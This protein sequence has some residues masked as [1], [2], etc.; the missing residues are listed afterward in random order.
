M[1][2]IT[3]MVL[4]LLLAGRVSA[5]DAPEVSG[6]R[7]EAAADF[8]DQRYEE[9]SEL[10]ARA[11]ALNP[12][13][14][15]LRTHLLEALSYAKRSE[16]NADMQR[17]AVAEFRN[18]RFTQS[19]DL[20]A[21]AAALTPDDPA[22]LKDWMWAL[23]GAKRYDEAA[24]VAARALVLHKNDEEALRVQVRALYY[25]GHTEDAYQLYIKSHNAMDGMIPLRRSMVHVYE[26]LREYDKAV[27]LSEQLLRSQPRDAVLY[28][29]VGRS[30]FYQGRYEEALAAW[31]T[32]VQLDP[33]NPRYKV[34]E[35]KSLFY[36]GQGP[37]AVASLK[38]IAAADPQNWEAADFLV[39][40]ALVAG[41]TLTAVSVLEKG[42]VN[43]APDDE[44]RLE[45][46]GGLYVGLGRYDKALAAF[47][48][49]IA[50]YP[51]SGEALGAKA[52]FL[53]TRG[54]YNDAIAVY[55]SILHQNPASMDSWAGLAD[56]LTAS[57]QTARAAA[58]RQE[59]LNRDPTNPYLILKL[60]Q[61]LYDNGETAES[62]KLLVDWMKANP[63]ERILP[64]LL[65]HGLAPS[66]S[67]P[68]LSSP[69]HLTTA[70]FAGQMAALMKAGFT[71][72]TTQQAVDWF[73]GKREIPRKI[74]PDHFRRR[75]SR[76]FPLCRPDPEAL[77]A[78]RRP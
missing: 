6:L 25:A 73:D 68:I 45:Q 58:A 27:E 16:V 62:R 9:A 37:A 31:R 7:K 59:A 56:A 42:L 28:A 52:N 78:S 66:S 26:N 4:V 53:F 21:A 22:L 23:W 38:K 32:A 71:S 20:Y 29:S 64:I 57:S 51:N 47:D 49:T 13:D 5:A 10:Y 43:P 15:D 24:A 72:I 65:Y 61:A 1:K 76:F 50:L 35:S 39:Q 36:A 67:D 75:P 46:L 40:S 14:A 8:N 2:R 34:F 3:W 69:I 63:D 74:R 54:K 60:S 33:A 55:Q 18:G 70:E 11:V 17:Q 19:A 30:R 12:G 48:R 41:D 77:R 44:Q